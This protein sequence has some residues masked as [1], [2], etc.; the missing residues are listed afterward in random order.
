MWEDDLS[1]TERVFQ[2]RSGKSVANYEEKVLTEMQ[3]GILYRP[4]D[5]YFPAVDMLW[6]EENEKKER[7]YY[8]IQVTFS[9]SHAKP[10]SVYEK[11]YRRLRLGDKDNSTSML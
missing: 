11:L 3:P 6:V 5:P 1:Q 9:K 10:L 4:C 8:G 2:F 7:V